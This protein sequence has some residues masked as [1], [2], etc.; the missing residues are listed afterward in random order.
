MPVEWLVAKKQKQI[1]FLGQKGNLMKGYWGFKE[2]LGVNR[3]RRGVAGNQ[4]H[5]AGLVW[6]TVPNSL[7]KDNTSRWSLQFLP[8][9][10]VLEESS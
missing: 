6:P 3:T 10:K 2:S 4:G 9:G 8:I 1:G 5:A 7:G